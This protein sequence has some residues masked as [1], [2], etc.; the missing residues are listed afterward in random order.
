VSN[1]AYLNTLFEEAGVLAAEMAARA[2]SGATAAGEVVAQAQAIGLKAVDEAER[3][4]RE[5]TESVAALQHAAE[6][7]VQAAAGAVQQVDA[8]MPEARAAATAARD[9]LEKVE[10]GILHL[11]QERVR[12]FQELDQSVQQAETGVESLATHIG[13]FGTQLSNRY[14]EAGNLLGNLERSFE[15]AANAVEK[16]LAALYEEFDGLGKVAA[17]VTNATAYAMEQLLTAISRG[18]LDH[19][20]DAT[21]YHNGVMAALR[22]GYLEERKDDAGPAPEGSG[23]A[24]DHTYINASFERVRG[25]LT[26]FEEVQDPVLA[27]LQSSSTAILQE[28]EEAVN[29]LDGAVRHLE[30]AQAAVKP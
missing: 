13:T 25:A 16:G 28:G 12:L 30:Q 3:L 2:L 9:M 20:H 22:L 4:H 8:L 27:L 24:E 7:A 14:Q 1:P 5:Y 21:G 10:G 6:Q 11:G 17:E 26:A 29:G 19:A 23:V 18:A 15:I